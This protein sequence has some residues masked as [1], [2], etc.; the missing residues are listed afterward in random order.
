MKTVL[1]LGVNGLIGHHLANRI[2]QTTDWH[3][4]GMDVHGDRVEG[5]L[6]NKRFHFVEGDITISREW[7]EYHVSKCD[8][9]LPLVAIS[10]PAMFAREPLRVFEVDFEANLRI[11]RQCV[12]HRT[13]LIFPSASEVYGLCSDSQ[14]E[15]TRS[16]LVYGPINKQ[17]WIYACS[18]QLMDRVI[19]A[20][21][22]ERG[23]QFTIFRPFNF[24]GF[25]LDALGATK[26]G[27]SRV[28]TQFLGHIMRGEDIRLVDGGNQRRSFTHIDDAIDALMLILNNSGNI[29]NG[30][31]YNIGN[32]DNNLS[33]RELAERMLDIAK[34]IPEFSRNAQR[35][36]LVETTSSAFYGTGYQDVMDRVP[37]IQNITADLGWRPRVRINEA[38]GQVFE[39]YRGHVDEAQ[40]HLA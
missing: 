17:R 36:R 15:P 16:N 4:Y 37:D 9:V 28:L 23:L 13:R 35:V 20:Y 6:G 11:V 24:I 33:I 3:V 2:I 39:A 19:W 29:A 10:T 7:V 18:K 12:E 30:K 25:G 38:L 21:G 14:F 26:E 40:N 27:T 22:F 31:I 5:L 32:P 1:I 34:K 8:L